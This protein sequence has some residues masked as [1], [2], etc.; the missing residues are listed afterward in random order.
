ML[1]RLMR[2][3]LKVICFYL[4]LSPVPMLLVKAHY[5]VLLQTPTQKKIELMQEGEYQKLNLQTVEAFDAFWRQQERNLNPYWVPTL[6]GFGLGVAMLWRKRWVWLV[7]LGYFSYSLIVRIFFSE[8]GIGNVIAVGF[9][10]WCLMYLLQP[11]IRT[12]FP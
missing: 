11:R 7:L 2:T 6:V 4:L 5:K 12:L 10:F 1:S 8:V 9:V 3:G